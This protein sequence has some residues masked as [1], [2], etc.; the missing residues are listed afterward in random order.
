MKALVVYDSVYG[1]TEQIA[2]AVAAGIAGSTQAVRVG[3]AGV[4]ALRSIDLLVVGSPTLGGRPSRAMQSFIDGIPQPVA[5]GLQVAAFDTRVAM[6]FAR[7][8]GWAAA[9]MAEK[10]K[11]SGSS[12]KA[13]PEGFIVKGRSGPLTEGEAERAKAWAKGISN[14]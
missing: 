13:P 5:K 10:L 9:R 14:S 11:A 1:N 12:L 3:A 6:K 8:F 2:K 7:I 4:D